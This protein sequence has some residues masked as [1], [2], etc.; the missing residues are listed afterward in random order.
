V[1]LQAALAAPLLLATT[2]PRTQANVD[3]PIGGY[4]P[5]NLQRKPFGLGDPVALVE[6]SEHKAL[7]LWRR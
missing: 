5:L 7:G 4:R 6:D 2:F 3:I 1:L